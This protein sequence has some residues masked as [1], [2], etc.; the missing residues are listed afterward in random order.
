MNFH[1]SLHVINEHNN[2]KILVFVTQKVDFQI[3]NV[4]KF[5]VLIIMSQT[6]IFDTKISVGE[7]IF[8]PC[9]NTLDLPH[10]VPLITLLFFIFR[11]RLHRLRI[12]LFYRTPFR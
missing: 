4:L 9:T 11:T 12:Y 3:K 5:H 1:A 6:L 2:L 10:T 8:L 7:F